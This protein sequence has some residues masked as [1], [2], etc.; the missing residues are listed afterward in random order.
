MD[1]G[2]PQWLWGLVATP[3][4]V[5]GLVVWRLRD[6]RRAVDFAEPALLARLTGG[7]R[8]RATLKSALVLAALVLALTAAARPRSGH[9]W[10][11]AQGS[12]VD[13]VVAIDVSTSMRAADVGFARSRLYGALAVVH[14]FVSRLEYDR[15]ALVTFSDQATT[16]CPM[17]ADMGAVLTMLEGVDYE[18]VGEGGTALAAAVR[19]ACERFDPKESRGRVVVVLSD[20][21]DQEQGVA[22]AVADAKRLGA[23]V[24]TVGLGTTEGARI[25]LSSGFFGQTVY[26]E[27]QG[28]TVVT[29]LDEAAL[30]RVA[31]DTGGTYRHGAAESAAE[32]LADVV[33]AAAGKGRIV[34]TVTTAREAYQGF[35]A[36]ALALLVVEML[37][38][39]R[40]GVRRPTA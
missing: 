15:V 13:V 30:R 22:D 34:R 2:Q 21:E 20:G 40:S 24:H 17:T 37:V 9:E 8:S 27:Y 36:L 18:S 12:G 33:R 5:A 19:E 31:N 1:F 39:S 6:R 16:V 3:L 7:G 26:K 10:Q 23:V 32:G 14:R 28:Q 11:T 35:V 29:R 38:P 4:G 25:P